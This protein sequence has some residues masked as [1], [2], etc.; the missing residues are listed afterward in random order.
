MATPHNDD[1][2]SDAELRVLAALPPNAAAAQWPTAVEGG[3]RADV[4]A[5]VARRC[6]DRLWGNCLVEHGESTDG[7]ARTTRGNEALERGEDDPSDYTRHGPSDEA[8]QPCVECGRPAPAPSP[9]PGGAADQGWLYDE[10]EQGFGSKFLCPDC[11]TPETIARW[12]PEE[13]P[14]GEGEA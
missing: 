4:P 11:Q 10:D 1:P 5:D 3:E 6:L 2:L 7:F 12:H 14:R 13:L 9:A 8:G